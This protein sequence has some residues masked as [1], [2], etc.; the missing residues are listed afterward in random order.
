MATDHA[1]RVEVPR[2]RY[3]RRLKVLLA[4][5]FTLL[6]LFFLSGM[7]LRQARRLGPF[8]E[9]VYD[10]LH[11]AENGNLSP[12]GRRLLTG[13]QEI[14]GRARWIQHTSG[15]LGVWG[16]GDAFHVQLH[17]LP[18]GDDDLKR[19]AANYGDGIAGLDLRNTNITDEGLRHLKAFPKL[20]QLV[21]GN[22][23][24]SG[25]P[26]SVQPKSAITDAGLVHLRELS[27][28]TSLSLSGLPITDDGLAALGELP[29]LLSL[30]LSRTKVQGPGLGRLQSLANLAVLDLDGSQVT[31]E[32]LHFLAGASDLTILSVRGL[33]LSSEGLKHLA[34]LP[35]LRQL[36]I[37]DC[38]L[39]EKDVREFMNGKPALGVVR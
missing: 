28:V 38:R 10:V 21:L 32:G 5:N 31:D 1:I 6:A 33:S 39:P 24:L 14:G 30:Y 4:I 19:L 27:H 26:A 16:G 17:G 18:I 22:E 3:G 25:L 12:S 20:R 35:Q 34:P 36:D 29:D 2:R 8:G 11:P 23:E 7:T 13:I 9:A 37:R 15:F